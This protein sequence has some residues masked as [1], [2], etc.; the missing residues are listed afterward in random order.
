MKQS[1]IEVTEEVTEGRRPLAVVGLG[2]V[3]LPLAAA[4]GRNNIE[5]IGFDVDEGKLAELRAGEDRT[6]EVSGENLAAAGIDYTSDPAKLAEAGVVIVTVP[7]PIHENRRPDLGPLLAASRAVGANMGERTVVVYESTVYPGVTEEVCVPALE[8]ASGRRLGEGF[9][10]GYSPERI[11][12]GDKKHTLQNVIKVVA[13]RTPE[14]TRSLGALY[15]KVA[16][17]GVFEARSIKTAEA[18]KVI[19]NTQRDLNIALMNE[20]S[21]IFHRLGIETH[22]VLDA[23]GTKWNFLPF[24]P[25]LVGGHCIGVDPY[26]LT[27][28]AEE[29]GYHPQV[30][31]AGRRINDGMGPY[32]AQATVKNLIGAGH[33]VKGARILVLG[34]TF[35]ENVP[36][37]RNSKVVDI[38]AELG[39]YG[40]EVD[41]YDPLADPEEVR[42]EY[43]LTPRGREVL[44]GNGYQAVILAVPHEEFRSLTLDKLK[45]VASCGEPPVLV[46]I[47]KLF[48]TDAAVEAGFRYWSL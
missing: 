20:L 35:K 34:L 42:R 13:G 26:Y 16:L 10:V 21:I 43:G 37:I 4:F 1:V 39:E 23:A 22:D 30:I 25:G 19:E 48:D 32:V 28:K 31:L 11:N 45:A 2:Y 44:D 24:T 27:Y 15:R 36:D 7:T 46:D 38:I 12:P 3:G 14:L 29:L 18:A 47:K 33:Q 6:G 5:V 40:V 8:K 9:D 17:A 41:V